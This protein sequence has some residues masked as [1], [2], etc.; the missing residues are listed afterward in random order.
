MSSHLRAI[1][2][3]IAVA[4]PRRC[5]PSVGL[6]GGA[7]SSPLKYKKYLQERGAGARVTCSLSLQAQ[8]GSTKPV[9]STVARIRARVGVVVHSQV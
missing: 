2:G 4:K 5:T 3:V 6:V 7:F 8:G 9:G 1:C